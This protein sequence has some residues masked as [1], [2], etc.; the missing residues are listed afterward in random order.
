MA[1]LSYEP[2]TEREIEPGA[3]PMKIAARRL[4]D[5]PF[6]SFVNISRDQAVRAL[7]PGASKT[8]I[9]RISTGKLREWRTL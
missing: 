8:Q 4:A 6:I 2:A 9:L 1:S 7:N 3:M 5:S